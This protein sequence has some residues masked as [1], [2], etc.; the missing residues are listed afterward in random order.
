MACVPFLHGQNDPL[1]AGNAAFEEDKFRE[2]L[3][4]YNQIEKI[5]KSAPILYKRGVCYYEINQLDNA[6]ADFRQ[7][8]EFGYKKPDV[9][10]YMGLIQHHLGNFE[11]AAEYYKNYLRETPLQQ[12]DR[13]RVRKLIKQCGRALDLSYRRPLAIVERGPDELNTAYDEINMIESPSIIGKYYYTSNHPTTSLS[14]STS[15]YDIY[16]IQS[17]STGWTEPKRLPYTIN[18]SKEDVLIGFTP[19][20]EG[21]YFYRGEVYDGQ[22]FLNTGKSKSQQSQAIALGEAF[23]IQSSDAFLYDQNLIL[24]SARRPEGYGVLDLYYSKLENGVWSKPSNLIKKMASEHS[25]CSTQATCM[26]GISGINLLI[27]VFRSIVQAMMI[28][29]YSQKMV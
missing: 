17:D 28:I 4:Y 29:S 21:I 1:K 19:N 8:W 16:S 3:I 18:K 2:A 25:M 20:A 23:N 13:P 12:G 22:F 14:M 26:K 5:S 27:L 24:F 6:V 11:Q 9:D 15:D 10:Y 7:A